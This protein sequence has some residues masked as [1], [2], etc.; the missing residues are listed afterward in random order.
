V[1]LLVVSEMITTLIFSKDRCLQLDA[2]LQSLLQHVE[3]AAEAHIKVIYKASSIRHEDQYRQLAVQWGREADFIQEVDFRSQVLDALDI[4]SR[5]HCIGVLGSNSKQLATRRGGA[6]VDSKHFVLFLVDD[7][8]FTRA[9]RLA[10]ITDALSMN[11]D[12]LGFSLRLGRNTTDCYSLLRVQRMPDF[13]VL[14]NGFLEFDWTAADGDFGYPLEISSSLYP[15]AVIADTLRRLRFDN[16]STLESQLT[17]HARRFASQHPNLVCAESSVAFCVP[18]NRVQR[19]F[20]NRAGES[21]EY[22]VER[23]ADWFDGGKRIDVDALSG[24]V[25]TAC[26]QEVELHFVQRGG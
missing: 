11:P 21:P 6:S 16:P 5:S 25:P 12:A 23:L 3:G 19:V 18:V 24:F 20:K 17:K 14:P 9:C 10:Q 4:R 22:S 1:R 2:T 8:I 13:A 7:C 26:H 15:M